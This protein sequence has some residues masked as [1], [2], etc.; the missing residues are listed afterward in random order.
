[1]KNKTSKRSPTITIQP[2][3][4][5]LPPQERSPKTRTLTTKRKILLPALA[6]FLLVCATLTLPQPA[7]ATI[8]SDINAWMCEQLRGICNWIFAG[9][10]KVLS[11]IGYE[12]I[13]SSGFTQMLG[14]SG[15]ITMYD[16]VYGAWEN[17]ILPIGCGILSFVFT[18][19][20]IKISQRMDGSQSMPAVREVVLLLVFFAVFL[21]LIQHSFELVQAVYEV[22]RLAISR[23]TNLF[24][25]GST[26]D[27]QQV[28]IVTEENDVPALVAMMLVAVVSWL[29]VIVAYIVA[30]V[31]SWARAIQIY[32]YACFA[33]IPLSLLALDETRQLGIGFIRNFA[34]VC[35]A[36]I[37]ILVI[38]VSFPIVLAG[39][40]AV[41]AGTGTAIDSVVGGLS[42]AL[43][44]VAMCILLI[45]SLIKSGTWARDVM[46]G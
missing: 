45:L 7:Y 41:S 29:V 22:T 35:L 20:L 40:N 25:T 17:A 26:L 19:Q 11:S 28:S 46:G 37:V 16:I 2:A 44:Y 21:F 12:G 13:L 42:Y 30:L 43:Q 10:V 9:Q 14:S 27:L 1:M 34:A 15:G 5:P 4:R 8:A 38:L 3:A 33:P 6:A 23:I 32:I 39:L 31:V 36:G 18:V 24:G